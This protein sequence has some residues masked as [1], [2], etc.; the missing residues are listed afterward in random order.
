MGIISIGLN[1]AS[2]VQEAKNKVYVSTGNLVFTPDET[3]SLGMIKPIKGKE[4]RQKELINHSA[5]C[6]A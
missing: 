3:V 5:V 2:A 4:T 6:Q 1:C